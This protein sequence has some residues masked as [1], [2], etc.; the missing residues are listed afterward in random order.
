MKYLKLNFILCLIILCTSACDDDDDKNLVK[1]LE[2]ELVND[3]K[4]DPTHG[5]DG[6]PLERTNHFT[7]FSFKNNTVVPLSDSATTK[8]DIGFRSTTIIVNGGTSGPGEG[9]AQIVSGIFEEFTQAPEG[10]YK[11]DSEGTYAIQG[12]DGWYNYTGHMGTPANA[13]I[14]IPGKTIMI[15]TAE[16]KYAK[17]EILSYYLGSPDT[18]TSEFADMTKRPPSRYYSF[19]FI[20]QPDG[21]KDFSSTRE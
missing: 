20:Y 14:P 16:G 15:K 2:A 21:S 19:R 6:T 11:A 7:F 8:W 17:M 5:P 3:L 4:A 1:T 9:E 10:G 18:T 12:T 13:I